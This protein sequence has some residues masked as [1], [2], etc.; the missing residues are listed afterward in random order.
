MGNTNNLITQSVDLFF[1]EFKY[2]TENTKVDV[3]V[4]AVPQHLL[5]IVE[6][7][8]GNNSDSNSIDFHDLLKAKSMSSKYS[9][10]IN[11]SINL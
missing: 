5:D 11:S 3:L 1:E 2:L 8:K 4:C 10:A 9:N 7:S 6:L